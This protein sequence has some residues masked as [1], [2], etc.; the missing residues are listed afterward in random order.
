MAFSSESNHVVTS[1]D[2][3]YR[4]APIARGWVLSQS[5]WQ[6]RGWGLRDVA[7]DLAA[8]YR[9][10]GHWSGRSLGE[11]VAHGLDLLGHAPFHVRSTIRPWSGTFA[12]VDRAARS[13]ASS[14]SARGVGPGDVVLLQLPNWV[15]AGIAFW[16]ATYLGSVVVP[17]VH[18]YGAKEVSHILRVTRPTVV[19]T[20]ERFGHVD[21][22]ANYTSMLSSTPVPTWLVVGDR[23]TASLPAGATA[24]ED[25]LDADPIG[26]PV[27]VD[28]ASPAVI[29][30]TSGTTQDPKG[31]VHSHDTL[32]FEARQLD[33][34][35]PEGGPSAITGAP[36]GHFIGMLNAF[37]VP[38]LRWRPVNLVDV[39]D[40]AAILRLMLDERLGMT[41]GSTFF[42]TSLL[43][44]P[45][46]TE[47][48]L[49]LLPFAGLGGSPVPE[50]V[51]TRARDLGIATFR[52]YGSTEH[53]SIT[54]C[55]IDEP[56]DKRMRTDGHALPG[57]EIRLDDDGEILSRGPDLFIGYT[58]P[59]LTDATVDSDG[60]Y[61]TGDIGAV[62]D[63]GYLTIT[64]RVSDVIIR[65]GENISAREVEELV[66]ELG[67]VAEVSVVAV[68]DDRM[69]E[70]AAA[71]LLLRPGQKAPTLETMREHLDGAGLARQK[72]PESIHVVD[73][74]PR[75]ASGKVQKFVLRDRLRAGTLTPPAE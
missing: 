56:E 46:F 63:D 15:E 52:S 23:P 33:W 21:H 1:L 6:E 66:S 5:V 38:L 50:A 47:E 39:W 68:P 49:G 69:G 30:F 24:F 67:S 45:D 31:V 27:V 28:P 70:R 4:R 35:F 8:S 26:G 61:R 10:A 59:R 16:G 12:D 9:E 3:S 20:P 42:L 64:D 71:V 18:F 29:G 41:G 60:W 34:M 14:L 75:T 32:G 7:P 53:P 73:E 2:A 62:D 51:T 36:V 72:W 19:V 44:H 11:V 13:F 22:L 48:H 54:G 65:G 40:P 74:M 37:I 55:R 58:D 57:V 25:L 43:D 17:V